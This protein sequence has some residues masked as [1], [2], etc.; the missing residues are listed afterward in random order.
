MCCG[1]IFDYENRKERL[2]E[3]ELE[4]AD[5]LAWEQPGNAQKLGQERAILEGVV[6]T[7][8]RLDRG[9]LEAKE[10]VDLAVEEQDQALGGLQ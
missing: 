8:D 2:T 6:A 4:L 9:L 1:G 7:I 3:V 5:P 10:I